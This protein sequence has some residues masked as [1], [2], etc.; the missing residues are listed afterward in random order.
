MSRANGLLVAIVAMLFHSSLSVAFD[1]THAKW[2]AV[3]GRYRAQDGRIHYKVFKDAVDSGKETDFKSYLSE[4]ASVSWTEFSSWSSN[5]RM[6]FLIN[7]Y[8]AF[9]VQLVLQHYPVESIKKIGGLFGSPWKKSF[10]SLV[11]GKIKSLDA[12]EHEYLRKIYKNP[13]IH[14]AINCAS[15]SC[16]PIMGRPFSGKELEK[17][18]ED[19]F[20]SFLADPFRNRFEPK[21]GKLFLSEI[22]KWFGEDFK[23]KYSGYLNAI[24]R[25]GPAAARDAIKAGGKVEWI[26]YDWTLNDADTKEG[27]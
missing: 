19:I 16:P 24:E 25:F 7:A 3:L 11:D 9:T 18:L 13:L 10:F 6:A 8:N 23:E 26:D 4:M 15:L 20:K 5:D 22:F 17:Q 27:H 2:G 1:Q 21:S 14:A 12:I